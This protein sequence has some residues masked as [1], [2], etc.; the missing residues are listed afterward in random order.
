MDGTVARRKQRDNKT[1][2]DVIYV[3]VGS[4]LIRDIVEEPRK[5]P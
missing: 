4:Q 2:G 3:Q 1:Q 5:R